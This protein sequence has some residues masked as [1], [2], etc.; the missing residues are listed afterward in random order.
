MTESEFNDKIDQTLETIEELLD[1][2]ETDLD[3]VTSGG[4]LTVICENQ[5][6]II[7]T[8]QAPVKQ[9][10]VAA[11]SGGFHFD[12]DENLNTWIRDSDKTPLSTFLVPIFQEQA[13]E[14]FRFEV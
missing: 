4:V 3:Y 13:G 9:L 10:W 7:F 1:E 2:A 11:R 14:T 8:R 5:S 6:Q 12:F